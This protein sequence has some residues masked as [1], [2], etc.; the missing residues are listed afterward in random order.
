M[1]MSTPQITEEPNDKRALE[2]VETG[3]EIIPSAKSNA[4]TTEAHCHLTN[5]HGVWKMVTGGNNAPDTKK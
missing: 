1:P 5:V 3:V 2:E 4:H